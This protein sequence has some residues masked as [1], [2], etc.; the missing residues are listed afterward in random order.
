MIMGAERTLSRFRPSL[1]VEV[2]GD[3]LGKAGDTPE[4]LFSHFGSIDYRG[5]VL[6]P[7]MQRFHPVDLERDADVLFVPSERSSMMEE[8]RTS[9]G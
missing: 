2:N 4:S 7:D 8:T 1:M 6:G 9:P 5:Y 3:A